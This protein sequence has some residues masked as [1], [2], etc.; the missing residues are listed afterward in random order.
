MVSRR[1][2]WGV[3]ARY[4]VSRAGTL[5]ITPSATTRIVSEVGTAVPIASCFSSAATQSAM[6][7]C[8]TSGRAA[9]WKRTPVPASGEP[10][11]DYDAH[12][13]A[14]DFPGFDVVVTGHDKQGLIDA[15]RLG[16]CADAV[17]H[18]RL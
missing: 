18:Q 6:I 5:A 14:D 9:S 12:L 11:L 10:A 16:E 17:L 7:C 1:K 2:P 15:R 8:G 4:R 3:C 13:V